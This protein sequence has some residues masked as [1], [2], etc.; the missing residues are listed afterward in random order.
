VSSNARGTCSVIVTPAGVAYNLTINDLSGPIMAAYFHSGGA[1]QTGA[2]VKTIT[3]SFEGNRAAGLWTSTD[4]EPLTNDLIQ[5]L[6]NGQIYV[7]VHTAQH[8]GGELR[9]QLYLNAVDGFGAALDPGQENANVTSS[10]SGSGS[11]TLTGIGAQYMVTVTGLTGP[12][13]AAHFHSGAAGTNGPVVRAIGLSGATTTTYGLWTPND[14]Q[15]LTISLMNDLDAGHIYYNVHTAQYGAGEIRGQVNPTFSPLAVGPGV[16][17][18][19]VSK[20]YDLAQNFPNPFNPSTVIKF[21]LG[22][23]GP[24]LLKV[25]NTLGQE[26]ATLANGPMQQG[27]HEINFNASALPSGVYFYKLEAGNVNL[28]RK[29][30]L[31]K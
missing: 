29:M 1:G 8:D 25:F 26:V 23:A 28:T 12:I 31:L 2:I 19:E 6:V 13:L 7:H 30:L 4:A 21:D 14:T 9:G 16:G 27:A 22:Q 18:P 10:G 17:G 24:V 20:T 15:A 3:G 5:Q 11:V